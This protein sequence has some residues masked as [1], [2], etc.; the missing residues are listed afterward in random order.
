MHGH[1]ASEWL[2]GMNISLPSCDGLQKRL[3]TL[4]FPSP[5]SSNCG[6]EAPLVMEKSLVCTPNKGFLHDSL[7]LIEWDGRDCVSVQALAWVEGWAAPL[8]IKYPH[9]TFLVPSKLLWAFPENKCLLAFCIRGT[10]S[11]AALTHLLTQLV[12]LLLTDSHSK[13]PRW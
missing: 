7:W 6:L 12:C 11:A 9:R 5:H 13:F 1:A 2:N 10:S 3:Q 8:A 4:P